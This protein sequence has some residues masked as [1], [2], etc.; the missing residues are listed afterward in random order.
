MFESHIITGPY[1]MIEL[2]KFELVHL[3]IMSVDPG[4]RSE[5]HYQ[6]RKPRGLT[7]AF[8]IFGV[9]LINAYHIYDN[10]LQHIPDWPKFDGSGVYVH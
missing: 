6:P 8:N 7:I 9:L 1:C 3:F 10:L 2:S 5:C 4:G